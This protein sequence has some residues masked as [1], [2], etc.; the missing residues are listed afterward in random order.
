MLHC[1]HKFTVTVCYLNYYN[2]SVLKLEITLNQGKQ[3]N[4]K[5]SK[6]LKTAMKSG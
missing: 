2:M 1:Y 3:Y 5:N 4:Y 6:T